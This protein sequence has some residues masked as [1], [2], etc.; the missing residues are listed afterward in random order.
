VVGLSGTDIKVGK[1]RMLRFD[2]SRAAV[3]FDGEKQDALDLWSRRRTVYL[4]M[5]NLRGLRG[6]RASGMRGGRPA[7]ILLP[8][9][10]RGGQNAL[11]G[12]QRS[13]PNPPE[14]RNGDSPDA[15]GGG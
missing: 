15:N 7:T 5:A 10:N 11:G 14:E 13:E 4:A 2:G 8:G 6:G 3:K 12:A 1:G 9:G